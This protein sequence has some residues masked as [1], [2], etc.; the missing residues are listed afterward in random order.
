MVGIVFCKRN[1][2]DVNNNNNG[3]DVI[4]EFVEVK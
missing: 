4:I 3:G 2:K 1:S